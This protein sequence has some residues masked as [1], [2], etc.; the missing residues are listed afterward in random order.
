MSNPNTKKQMEAAYAELMEHLIPRLMEEAAKRDWTAVD[1]A[2]HAFLSP[3]TVR[4]LFAG[5][6]YWPQL[7]TVSNLCAA[8][9][10]SLTIT[11]TTIKLAK[12]RKAA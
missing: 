8:F 9:G 2:R 1:L 7:R 6:T 5:D 3:S 12:Y 10:V 4:R 11:A